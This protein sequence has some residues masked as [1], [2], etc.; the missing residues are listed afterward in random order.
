MQRR[1]GLHHDAA[2][3]GDVLLEQA[4]EGRRVELAEAVVGRIGEVGDDEVEDL[5]RGFQPLQRIGVDDLQFGRGQR[6][7]R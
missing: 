1:G 2:G 3:F 7:R 5:R 4:V 6:I